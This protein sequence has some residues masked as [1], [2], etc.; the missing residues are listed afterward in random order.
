MPFCS[1]RAAI[2]PNGLRSR[3]IPTPVAVLIRLLPHIRL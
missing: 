1:A 3:E 2:H